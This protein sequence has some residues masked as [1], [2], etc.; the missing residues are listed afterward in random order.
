MPLP[1]PDLD[2]RRFD[3]LSAE[4]QARLLRQLPELAQIAPGDPVHAFVDLF[5]WLTET[6]I[7]RANRI[8]E[9]QQ[10]AF[11][12]LLQIPLRPARPARGI[13]CIDTSGNDTHLP[14]LLRSETSLKAGQVSFSTVGELQPLPL[15]LR[16][17]VKEALDPGQLTAAGISL[18]Q[19]R[20]QYRVEP[21]AFR[22]RSLIPGRDPITTIGTADGALYLALALK[23]PQLVPHRDKVL[24]NIAGTLINIGLAPQ[25]EVDG[26]IATTLAPR[27]LQW[28]LA[29]WPEAG[30]PGNVTYLPLELIHDSSQGGRRTGVARL[31]LPRDAGMLTLPEAVDPQY[32]GVEDTPP[33]AP[34]G[35]AAGQLLFWLR[36]RCADDDLVLGYIGINA[37]DVEGVGVAR[38][39]MVG[40][41]TDQPDQSIALPDTDIDENS[42][43]IEVE[44]LRQFIPWQRVSHFAGSGPGDRV[45]TLDAGSG[46]IR[47]GDG[48]RGM[49]PGAG[50]RI[51]AASY[52]HG[53]GSSGNLPGESITSVDAGAGKLKV[54]QAWPT[55]GGV[56]RESVADAERRIPAFLGHRDRAVTGDDFA[57]LAL[58][59]PL[60]PVARANAIPGFFP[61]S[62][63]AAV[64][65]DIP[66]VVSLFI[67]PPVA[68]ALGMAPRPSA[69]MIREVYEHLSA[70]TLL[71]TELYVLSPQYQPVAISL[72]LEVTDPATEQQT[73]RAVEEALLHYLWPL[74]PHGPRS[75]GWPLKRAVEINELRTQA[76]RVN[77]VEAV[78]GLR[79]FYQDLDT[80]QWRELISSQALPLTDYQLPQLMAVSIQPGEAQPA[81]PRG[82]APGAAPAT[83]GKRP[84]PVPVIPDI[85]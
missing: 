8:P 52:R 10:R 35:L 18:E 14:P 56:D 64:R 5:A 4:L 66:G 33:E 73:L 15:E 13:V 49:R 55:R 42:L 38:D 6:V 2:D 39:L 9:R 31:R 72:S 68:P 21:A 76:G 43:Q 51:R 84:V 60:R 47:F 11:L 1:I 58:D 57:Q 7:Y 65:R 70:R 62:S 82:F 27:R 20:H 67:L 16:L 59:N 36:L 53:G 22:P 78:N 61:G 40:S 74:P 85:C 12:N 71:G 48:I 28:D 25:A 24:R 54:R 69:G 37:I 80:K 32:A 26:D 19:L 79:L 41:G 30:Q 77:G 17:L 63:L 81:P 34:A 50:A 23:K 75:D 44:E 46:T 29:W 3:D 83:G 45:Y